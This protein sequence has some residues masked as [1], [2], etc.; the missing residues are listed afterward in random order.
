LPETRKRDQQE[1]TFYI[2]LGRSLT[3]TKGWAASETEAAYVSAGNLCQQTG[4]MSQLASVLWGL[5]HLYIVRAD[6][7]K[8]LEVEAQFHTLA[9]QRSDATHLMVAHWLTGQNLTVTG[10]YTTSLQHLEQACTRYDPK[11]HPT[12]V[13]LFGVD[14]GVFARSYMS[15]TLWVLGYPEQAVQRSDEALALAQEMQ[16]PFSLALAQAYAAMLHQFRQEPLIASQHAEMALAL[17]TEHAI[18]YY[19][20]WATIIQGW[21]LSEQGRREEGIVQM[22]QGLTRLQETGGMLRQSYYLALLAEAYGHT[23]KAEKGLSLLVEALAGSEPRIVDGKL[24]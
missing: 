10:E 12:H 17:G 11:Q 9:K 15:H 19:S 24:N 7:T 16:H 21:S 22:Q 13:A 2:D 4:D 1:L 5:S 14:V 20:A 6:L 3:A 23:E 8:S 18:A